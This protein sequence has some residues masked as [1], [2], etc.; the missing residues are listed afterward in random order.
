MLETFFNT[1]GS[2]I[3]M[4]STGKLL[5]QGIKEAM[6]VVAN[7]YKEQ[8]KEEGRRYAREL[9][10][11]IVERVQEDPNIK[12]SLLSVKTLCWSVIAYLTVV[13]LVMIF[14]LLHIKRLNTQLLQ[15]LEEFAAKK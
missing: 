9:G 14:S 13:T 6:D 7:E 5:G 12:S 2:D 11:K 3:S 1:T 4:S 8:Y 15:K 10:D